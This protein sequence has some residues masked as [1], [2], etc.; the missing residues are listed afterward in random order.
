MII[1]TNYARGMLIRCL[2]VQVGK[3]IGFFLY[4]LHEFCVFGLLGLGPSYVVHVFNF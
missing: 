2:K 1:I 4:K 3:F